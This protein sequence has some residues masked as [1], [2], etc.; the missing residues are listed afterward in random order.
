MNTVA[1]RIDV[2]AIEFGQPTVDSSASYL[3]EYF[4]GDVC[5]DLYG[6]LTPDGY[7]IISIALHKT[8]VD[9]STMF[10][11]AQLR[12]AKNYCDENLP[13]W[14][15]RKAEDREEAS[16]YWRDIRDEMRRE[17]RPDF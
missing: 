16:E 14:E 8:Q 13:S 1:E 6:E 4:V 17:M 9:L 10:T 12:E 15:Q 7:E 5:L 11:A 2:H 3:A